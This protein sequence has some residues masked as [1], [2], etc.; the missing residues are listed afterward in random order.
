MNWGKFSH[1]QGQ[2]SAKNF[3]MPAK[4]LQSTTLKL[5]TPIQR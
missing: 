1:V 4:D 5:G 2:Q 3:G